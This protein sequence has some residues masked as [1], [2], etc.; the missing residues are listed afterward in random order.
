MAASAPTRAMLNLCHDASLYVTRD[1]YF[2][3]KGDN[4]DLISVSI[5]IIFMIWD[6]R[7]KEIR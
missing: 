2:E 1:Q 6:G 7:S 4:D 3:K 5:I